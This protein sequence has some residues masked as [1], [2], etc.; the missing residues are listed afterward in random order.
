[1]SSKHC[2]SPLVGA[3]VDP[4]CPSTAQQVLIHGAN[5]V[6]GV[7]APRSLHGDRS[8]I[9]LVL[10]VSL[11]L[12]FAYALIHRQALTPSLIG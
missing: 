10:S 5:A 6:C 7:P 8:A 9:A 3:L 2:Y 1:M 11:A 4:S 12:A